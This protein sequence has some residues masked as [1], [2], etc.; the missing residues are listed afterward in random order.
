[1]MHRRKSKDKKAS[2]STPTPIDK[3]WLRISD[4][5]PWSTA[6][7]LALYEH[8]KFRRIRPSECMQQMFQKKPSKAP[9][10]VAM[11]ERFNKVII[12]IV[13]DVIFR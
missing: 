8:E 6:C 2:S 10:I 9:N 5:D 4:I 13:I 11:V 12:Y 7:Q 3:S 1:M